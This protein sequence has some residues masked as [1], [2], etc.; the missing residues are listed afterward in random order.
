[1]A[2]G[3]GDDVLARAGREVAI[4]DVDGDAL[5]AL[6]L[7]A[8]G[9]QG[10]VDRAHAALLRGLLD[11]VQRVGENG[12]GVEQQAADQGALAVVDAAAGQ[13]AQQAVIFNWVGAHQK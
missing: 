13:E 12:L 7:Q 11:G 6:G 1:M 3:V 4:G 9:E 10:Q 2:R 5:F 8:V